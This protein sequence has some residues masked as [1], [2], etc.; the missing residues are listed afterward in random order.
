MKLP[1]DIKENKENLIEKRYSFT[2]LVDTYLKRIRKSD[3]RINSFITITEKAAYD[4][5]RFFDKE[6]V[7]KGSKIFDQYPLAGVVVSHKDMFLTKGIKTT[8]GSKVLSDYIPAYSSTVVEKLEK[9]G[10]ILIGKTNQDAWGHGSSGENSD[11]GPTKNPWNEKMVSGGSSSGSAA[12]VSMQFSMIATGT[13]TCGSVRVP[14]NYC[15][16]VG[17]KPTYGSVSRY[18]VIAMASSLDSI[19]HMAKTTEDVESVFNIT[20]GVDSKDAN[21]SKGKFIRE[22]NPVIGIPKE[23]FVEG[24]DSQIKDNIE[25]NIKLLGSL[26]YK[27]KEVSLPLTKNAIS[28]YYIIMPAEVSS[29]LARYDGIRYGNKRTS[30]S[31]EA[32]RRIMLGS[33]VLSSGYIDKYYLKAAKVRTE[34][35]KEMDKVFNEVDMLIAPVAPTPPFLLGEKSTDPMKMYLN[36]IYSAT[37]SITGIPAISIPS[38]FTK[39]GLPLGFQLM[40]PKFS[41][42]NLFD[43]GKDYQKNT[44]HHLKV[45][46]L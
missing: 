14:A 4:R 31:E 3:K 35:I 24:L 34:I 26:G 1:L 5:V 19:G 10:C 30:F 32:K 38:G 29:N 17:L 36:D 6:I 11:F 9:A 37:A 13:D 43:L 44:S 18:G 16:I 42:C 46:I 22:N 25:K 15:G 7:S 33:Y 28:V 8:A 20:K 40:G 45:P 41:E 21:V 2:E 12:A 23:F 39:G 27:F